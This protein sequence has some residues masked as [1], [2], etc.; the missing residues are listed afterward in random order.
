MLRVFWR[1]LGGFHVALKLRCGCHLQLDRDLFTKHVEF[2]SV[3]SC[4]RCRSP[5]RQLFHEDP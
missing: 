4:V 2:A 1:A 5:L 3:P